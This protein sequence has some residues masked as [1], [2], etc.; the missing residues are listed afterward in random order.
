MRL[1]SVSHEVSSDHFNKTL[2]K[3]AGTFQWNKNTSFRYVK[4]ISYDQSAVHILKMKRGGST[5]KL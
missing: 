2:M 3:M 1:I 4:E 5:T